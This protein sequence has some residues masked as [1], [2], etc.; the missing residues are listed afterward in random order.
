MERD[1]T[2]KQVRQRPVEQLIADIDNV[3]FGLEASG[4]H[5]SAAK[6]EEV[7]ADILAATG[8]AEPRS[9]QARLE[10]LAASDGP[11]TATEQ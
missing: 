5:V 1:M 6:M 8:I 10:R 2:N 7:M 3:I 4:L 11:A 9:R